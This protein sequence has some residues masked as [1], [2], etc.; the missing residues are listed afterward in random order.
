MIG[1]LGR[2]LARVVGSELCCSGTT[3]TCWTVGTPRRTLPDHRIAM[4]SEPTHSLY[5]VQ[6]LPINDNF[7]SCF[8]WQ[9]ANIYV[10]LLWKRYF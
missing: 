8:F 7:G 5:H 2:Q 3:T 4:S 6:N 9:S 1:K 10:N